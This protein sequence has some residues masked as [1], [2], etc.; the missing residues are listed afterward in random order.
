VALYT[1]FTKREV[2]EEKQPDGTIKKT[3]VFKHGGFVPLI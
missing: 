1:T 3:S 2:I